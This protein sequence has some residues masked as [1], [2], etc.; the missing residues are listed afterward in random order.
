MKVVYNR[1]IRNIALKNLRVNSKT[2]RF[3]ICFGD[4]FMV[5]KISKKYVTK[6]GLC[7]LFD[8]CR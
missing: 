8:E 1:S 2:R 6:E 5:K 4:D 3:A 7:F